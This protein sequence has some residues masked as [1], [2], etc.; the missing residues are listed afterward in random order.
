MWDRSSSSDNC[1]DDDWSL[2]NLRNSAVWANRGN[3]ARGHGGRG[4]WGVLVE[5]RIGT[6]LGEGAVRKSGRW[7]QS[8]NYSWRELDGEQGRQKLERGRQMITE[9][10]GKLDGGAFDE[11]KEVFLN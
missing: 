5:K 7:E 2:G 1:F 8:T 9:A 10:F 3:W 6:V 4:N 11:L